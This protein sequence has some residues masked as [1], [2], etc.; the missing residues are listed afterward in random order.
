MEKWGDGGAN[1]PVC[2]IFRWGSDVYSS[3]LPRSGEAECVQLTSS[4]STGTT[5]S[6]A[7]HSMFF[8]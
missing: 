8:A 3:C 1:L 6:R 2:H 4:A 7:I 5:C